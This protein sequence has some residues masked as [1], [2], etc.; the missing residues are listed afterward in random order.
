[1]LIAFHPDRDER[2]TVPQYT[3][4]FGNDPKIQRELARCPIPTCNQ[5]LLVV[6]ASSTGAVAHFAH[7]RGSDFCP[8]KLVSEGPY[9]NLYPTEPDLEAARQLRAAFRKHLLPPTEN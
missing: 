3:P 6:A 7:Q 5:R 4:D 2:I 8:S 9:R 1:M